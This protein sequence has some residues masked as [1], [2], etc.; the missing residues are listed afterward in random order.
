MTSRHVALAEAHLL[1]TYPPTTTVFVR[2]Q[3]T[4]LIDEHGRSWL[5]LLGGLAV[6]GLGHAH[7]A[8]AYWAAFLA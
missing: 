7:P 4:T 3:G 6:V 8:G 1:R 5:D 2:G